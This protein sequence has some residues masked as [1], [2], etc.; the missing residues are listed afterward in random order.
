MF[1][2]LV[3]AAAYGMNSRQL[4]RWLAERKIQ[5]RP[6][7]QHCIKVQRIAARRRINARWPS[8]SIATP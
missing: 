2:L 5:S 4:L 1:T 8:G 7:W 6:L 3:D